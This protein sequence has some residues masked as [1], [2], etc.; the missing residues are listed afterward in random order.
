MSSRSDQDCLNTAIRMLTRRDHSAT[1]LARKLK[2][3]QFEK[4]RIQ[5]TLAKCRRLH[6]L[7]DEKF[8]ANYILQLQRRGYGPRRIRQ[9]LV[10]KGLERQLITRA[11]EAS[12]IEKKEFAICQAVLEKKLKTLIPG[13]NQKAIKERLY[14]FLSARGFSPAVIRETLN[15][16]LS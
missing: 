4:D 13:P 10:E 8:A 2:Q 6:Y 15:Q 5:T 7:D 3:R 12:G 14:R 9:K 11:L 16:I 1:E